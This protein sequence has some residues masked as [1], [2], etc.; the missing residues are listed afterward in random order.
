MDN[1]LWVLRNLS[2]P[3]PQFTSLTKAR[4]PSFEY[5]EAASEIA[6]S[7]S[8]SSSS[9]TKK[10]PNGTDQAATA[11]KRSKLAEPS[12]SS[13]VPK[14]TAPKR[15]TIVLDEEPTNASSQD[16]TTSNQPDTEADR[17]L[18]VELQAKFDKE[19][20]EEQRDSVDATKRSPSEPPKRSGAGAG[21]LF[22][23]SGGTSMT[24]KLNSVQGA[25]GPSKTHGPS[26]SPFAC[27]SLLSARTKLLPTHP[28]Q[29]HHSELEL[30]ESTSRDILEMYDQS[31]SSSSSSAKQPPKIRD[32]SSGGHRTAPIPRSQPSSAPGGPRS[33]YPTHGTIMPQVKSVPRK[34]KPDDSRYQTTIPGKGASSTSISEK[35]RISVQ[36]A[37]KLQSHPRKAIYQ[38]EDDS[39]EEKPGS[40]NNR[41]SN[42]S[43]KSESSE[44]I[45]LDIEDDNDTCA[46]DED[47]DE[48]ILGDLKTRPRF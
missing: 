40:R 32:S 26:P 21:A 33:E 9:N 35:A 2:G 44:F 29:P 3:T 36:L 27:P 43:T 48:N 7:S 34:E 12:S 6:P 18:A 20:R 16:G 8:S 19:G 28:L 22:S 25:R 45:E 37:N 47:N 24:Q 4:R 11:P 17:Q 15:Q 5:P 23:H 14:K 46:Q 42:R 31:A 13:A 10:R 39:T 38:E 41:G 1:Y 30:D